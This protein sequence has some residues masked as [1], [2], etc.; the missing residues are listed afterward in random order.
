ASVVPPTIWPASFTSFAKAVPPPRLPRSVIVP[1]SQRVARGFRKS[2]F[3]LS[4]TIWPSS[5][6]ARAW[7]N[8]SSDPRSWMK[9]SADADRAISGIPAI[10]EA[11]TRIAG[12]IGRRRETHG[13]DLGTRS[14]YPPLDAK[15]RRHSLATADGDQPLGYR[16]PRTPQTRGFLGKGIGDRR[17][18]HP[19]PVP[20]D[21]PAAERHA[22]HGPPRSGD[23]APVRTHLSPVE[24]RR[25]WH[26]AR[27]GLRRRAATAEGK[28]DPVPRRD[29]TEG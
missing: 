6:T 24:L 29:Q 4:P 13:P 16:R 3:V 12:S 21:H 17:L 14:R 27:P 8:E 1:F 22:P 2:S 20:R 15:P 9:P 23:V 10:S 18:Q 26:Q 28:D 11:M 7:L 5:L 19:V 25:G